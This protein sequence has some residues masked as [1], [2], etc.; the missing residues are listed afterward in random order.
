MTSK[1][2]IYVVIHNLRHF[3][4]KPNNALVRTVFDPDPLFLPRNNS[5]PDMQIGNH[6]LTKPTPAL[7]GNSLQVV[8]KLKEI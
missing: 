2:R 4:Q 7:A 1:S 3:V 6:H 8:A 5:Y